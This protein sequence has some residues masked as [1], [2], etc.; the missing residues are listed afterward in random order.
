MNSTGETVSSRILG[1]GELLR[2][3]DTGYARW[4][5]GAIGADGAEIGNGAGVQK[6]VASSFRASKEPEAAGRAVSIKDAAPSTTSAV[7]TSPEE[8]P[9][10]LAVARG[11][12]PAF[13][14][15]GAPRAVPHSKPTAGLARV[16]LFV[17]MASSVA[18]LAGVSAVVAPR[19]AIAAWP[20]E[21]SADRGR[22]VPGPSSSSSCMEDLSGAGAVARPGRAAS[23]CRTLLV[24]GEASPRPGSTSNEGATLGAP[25]RRATAEERGGRRKLS[26]GGGAM[27]ARARQNGSVVTSSSI[28]SKRSS[29]RSKWCSGPSGDPPFDPSSRRPRRL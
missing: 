20:P 3:A 1:N 16:F 2:E 27:Q 7:L 19:T 11:G 22:S 6:E 26:P 5:L 18:L 29:F 4:G 24:R 23:S 25:A 8:D 9:M 12:A 21:S 17:A 10:L 14:A 15:G 13:S 28:G